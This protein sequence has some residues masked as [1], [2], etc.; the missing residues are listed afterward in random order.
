MSCKNILVFVL[1]LEYRCC[2]TNYKLEIK[3]ETGLD[4]D[5]QDYISLNVMILI[6]QRS[7]IPFFS[8]FLSSRLL[9]FM[10]SSCVSLVFLPSF[11]LFSP[12]FSSPYIPSLLPSFI[13]LPVFF[14]PDSLLSFLSS[15]LSL[16]YSLSHCY[17]PPFVSYFPL[18]CCPCFPVLFLFLPSLLP[19]FLLAYLPLFFPECFFLP[20]LFSSLPPFVSSFFPLFFLSSLLFLFCLF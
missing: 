10:F 9:I 20:T 12:S 5:V 6:P 3:L 19:H 17:L 13:P 2:D 8:V 18:S 16:P 11:L 7:F 1:F 15:S 4:C 14:L